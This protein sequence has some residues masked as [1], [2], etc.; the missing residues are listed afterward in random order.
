MKN[1]KENQQTW[2]IIPH[3]FSLFLWHSFC[4]SISSVVRH[5]HSLFHSLSIEWNVGGKFQNEIETSWESPKPSNQTPKEKRG[6]TKKYKIK[7][8]SEKKCEPKKATVFFL[9]HSFGCCHL[10][11]VFFYDDSDDMRM[12]FVCFMDSPEPVWNS[13]LLTFWNKARHINMCCHLLNLK[14]LSRNFNTN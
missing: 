6:T 3:L 12:D 13:A 9:L 11:F 4:F 7:K 10:C 8:M 1:S 2:V 14:L 5:A